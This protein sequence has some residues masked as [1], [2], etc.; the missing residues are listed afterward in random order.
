[1]VVTTASKLMLAH[2]EIDD[3]NEHLATCNSE[4]NNARVKIT[5]LETEIR[6]LNVLILSLERKNSAL[7][8]DLNNPWWKFWK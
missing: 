5:S 2:D 1:M 6:E 3:L 4:L 8:Y 7:E